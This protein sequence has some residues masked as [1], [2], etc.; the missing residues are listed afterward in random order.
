MPSKH[1]VTVAQENTR[2]EF[3]VRLGKREMNRKEKC[4]KHVFFHHTIVL[5]SI[6][7][8]LHT[9]TAVEM[10][11]TI[12]YQFVMHLYHWGKIII[13]QLLYVCLFLNSHLNEKKD[14]AI[15]LLTSLV[16]FSASIDDMTSF[17]LCISCIQAFL[18]H[19]L[20][21]K[22]SDTGDV[23]KE[24]KVNFNSHLHSV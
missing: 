6:F 9:H 15:S 16:Q 3:K 14:F 11:C 2:P 5:N 17:L 22:K 19:W 24:V 18:S 8:S 10:Y 7:I 1:I 12:C 20:N 13:Q 21:N 4:T 23:P